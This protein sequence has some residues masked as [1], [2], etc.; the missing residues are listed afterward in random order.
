[1]DLI[2]E[3][4][5]YQAKV[6]DCEWYFKVGDYEGFERRSMALKSE[7]PKIVSYEMINFACPWSVGGTLEFKGRFGAFYFRDRGGAELHIQS[8]DE[9]N[10]LPREFNGKIAFNAAFGGLVCD[11]DFCEEYSAFGSDEAFVEITDKGYFFVM[12]R[13]HGLHLSPDLDFIESDFCE[14]L[15]K[16]GKDWQRWFQFKTREELRLEVGFFACKEAEV[17][18]LR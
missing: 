12:R 7:A 18:Y 6:K 10:H 13:S 8:L 9:W 4:W 5:L 16:A 15:Q 3:W 17:D 11:V 14:A 2:K 1:M